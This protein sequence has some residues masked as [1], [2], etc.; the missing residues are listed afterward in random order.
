MISDGIHLRRV[1]RQSNSDW[2]KIESRIRVVQQIG[3]F[4]LRYLC[5]HNIMCRDTCVHCFI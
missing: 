5:R 2:R 4:V 3:D 1:I